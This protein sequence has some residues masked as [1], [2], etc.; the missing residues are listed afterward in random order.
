MTEPT[1]VN[2]ALIVP[3]TG[4]L[5]DT[6]GSDAL[7]PDMVAIDGMLGGFAS[8]SLSSLDV[9]LTVPSGFV[10]TPGAGPTQSQNALITFSGPLTANVTVTFPMPGFYL[11]YNLTTGA[12]VVKLAS[13]SPGNIICA[14]PGEMV[15]VFCD[16][17]NMYY[18]GLSRIGSYVDIGA[19]VVPSWITSCTVPPYLNCDGS[20]FNASTYPYLNG[21]LGGN[22]LPD[23]RGRGRFALNQTTG[24]ITTAGSGINGDALLSAGGSQTVSI[25]QTN[26]PSY[27]LT[28]GL[29][30][31]L[32]GPSGNVIGVGSGTPST[33]VTSGGATSV[34]NT[35]SYAAISASFTGS[36]TSGGSGT[37]LNKM[38]PAYIGGLTLIRAA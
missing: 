35:G 4:D 32:S 31:V 9:T 24:R 8:I 26:I 1:T 22:T 23:S 14:P 21:L 3:N 13:S 12:F 10:A 33:T 11:V 15:Q 19:T 36:I 2:R 38:P 27:T 7:N 16:G 18:V 20:T 25:L 5:P 30:I 6:W 28:N 34:Y 29:S 37:A 17:T